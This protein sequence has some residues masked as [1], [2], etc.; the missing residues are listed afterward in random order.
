MIRARRRRGSRLSAP[1]C[2]AT[3]VAVV[4]ALSIPA[5][6]TDLRPAWQAV[7]WSPIVLDAEGGILSVACADDGQV[8]LPVSLD[9]AGPWIALATIAA[10]DGRFGRH[11]GVDALAAARALAQLVM[12]RGVV[13][14]A[15]TIAMQ[16]AKMLDPAPRTVT[17]KVR[18]ALRALRLQHH[19]GAPRLLEM[20]LSIA[21]YGGNRCGAEAAAWTYFGR[22][23]C[24]LTLGEAALLAGLP[25]SPERLRPDRFPEA[26]LRRRARVLERMQ[27]LGMIDGATAAAAGAEPVRLASGHLPRRHEVAA[28]AVRRRSIGS[29]EPVRSLLRP[30]MQAMARDEAMRIVRDLPDGTHAAIVIMD[31]H[32]GAFRAL[33]TSAGP[34]DGSAG[35]LPLFEA[36]RSPGSALKP[37][38]AATAFEADRL[39][40]QSPLPDDP[41]AYAGW[42]PANMDD[43]ASAP[44]TRLDAGH[45]PGGVSVPVDDA[46]VRSLNRPWIAVLRELGPAAVIA[47]MESCGVRFEAGRAAEAG[48]AL[49]T[50]AAEVRLI[51]LVQAYAV[52]PRDGE[53]I[54]G[55]FL[56]AE[57]V[58]VARTFT[59]RTCRAIES[60]LSRRGDHAAEARRSAP[61]IKTGT[62]A[63][64]VD[65]WAL[66]WNDR[67]VVGAW[68]GRPAG[69]GDPILTGARVAAPAVE[70][71][72]EDPRLGGVART[73]ARA[74]EPPAWTPG[75]PL[76]LVRDAAHAASAARA[77]AVRILEPAPDSVHLARSMPD[78]VPGAAAVTTV[79]R[80]WARIPL[81]ADRPVRW[82]VDGAP[83][84]A[85][86]D[87]VRL[88]PGTWE[89]LAIDAAGRTARVVCTVRDASVHFPADDVAST[90]R[91]R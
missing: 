79:P 63:G 42:R 17:A 37:F 59:P 34:D 4:A 62:S 76:M 27:R 7:P 82:F 84:S 5:A 18:E 26:A 90:R 65:A 61:P 41:V 56:S 30:D 10:E 50:G 77:A 29:R 66:G 78:S 88:S 3:I 16:V 31:W 80:P 36:W 6:T 28:A 57:P 67:V 21:P 83:V 70:R 24:D 32:D 12:Q 46:L 13:S 38:I 2:A 91:V 51:D 19:A 35:W 8:R 54:G 15:S 87:H 53:S 85:P 39:G 86:F 48:L 68:V 1:G 73:A 44:R 25:Q 9:A 14:G 40:P 45:A 20:Y 49:A 72:L 89:I 71:L 55:R 58:R 43:A 75:R 60:I 74:D 22:S 69:G 47:T 81:R 64:H 11:P 33:A 23:L 52:F